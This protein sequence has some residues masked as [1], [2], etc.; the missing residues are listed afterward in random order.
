MA[1][2]G[3]HTDTLIMCDDY[4]EEKCIHRAQALF[5][6]SEEEIIIRK[7]AA[8]EQKR[9]YGSS[10]RREALPFSISSRIKTRK[11]YCLLV[12]HQHREF[13]LCVTLCPCLA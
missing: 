1:L 6:Q 8:P 7:A 12:L 13:N 9:R 3:G 5:I 2:N 11:S 4:W 10:L